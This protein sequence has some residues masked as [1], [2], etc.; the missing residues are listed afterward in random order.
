[1]Q[2]NKLFALCTIILVI[3]ITACN[4]EKTSPAVI[5]EAAALKTAAEAKKVDV[6]KSFYPALEKGDWAAIEKMVSPDFTDYGPWMPASG[7][8]G[9]DTAIKM[10]KVIREAFPDMKYEVLHTAVND[11]MV[12]V[13]YRFTGSND[14]PLMGNPA[15]NK[16]IDHT[17]VDMIQVK[18]S[19][20]TAHWDYSD[21]VTYMKQMG[22][23][24]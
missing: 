10:L 18:D 17:G 8:K 11:D 7:V 15:T 19:L 22:L 13:H 6:V 1:M 16:K 23:M 14:G 4:Q 12:F 3:A 24:P 5:T 21:Q 2:P 9:R 20:V